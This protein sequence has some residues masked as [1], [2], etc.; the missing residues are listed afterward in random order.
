MTGAEYVGLAFAKSH[1][2]TAS[3]DIQDEYRAALGEVLARHGIAAEDRIAVPYVVDCWIA[4]RMD[5]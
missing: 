2:R 5:R 3:A 4:T 1:L